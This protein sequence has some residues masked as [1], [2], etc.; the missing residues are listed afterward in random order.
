MR[1]DAM[2]IWMLLGTFVIPVLIGASC[3]EFTKAVAVTASAVFLGNLL[4]SALFSGW[5]GFGSLEARILASA[6]TAVGAA[7]GGRIRV[8]A[9]VASAQPRERPRV[10]ITLKLAFADLRYLVPQRP[11]AL[12]RTKHSNLAPAGNNL[13]VRSGIYGC[14]AVPR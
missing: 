3:E 12:V 14:A 2:Q 13:L 7:R 9:H 5:D 6:S 1:Y 8:A 10:G 4:Y 11:A